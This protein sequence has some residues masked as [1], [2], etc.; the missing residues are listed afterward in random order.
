[1]SDIMRI[2]IGPVHG[3]C[4]DCRRWLNAPN[5]LQLCEHCQEIHNKALENLR[6][7]LPTKDEATE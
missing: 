3:Y 4:F 7:I 5:R 2:K 6:S 1:M